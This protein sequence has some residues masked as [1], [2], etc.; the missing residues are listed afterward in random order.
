M[1][2][3][4]IVLMLAVG[5]ASS[6]SAASLRGQTTDTW[7]F[8]YTGTSAAWTVPSTGYYDISASGAQ[9]GGARTNTSS[10]YTLGGL[11]AVVGGGFLL[12]E[13]DVISILVGGVGANGT[14]DSS[15]VYAGGGGG[16]SFVVLTGSVPLVVAGGGGGASKGNNKG[17]YASGL[18][19]STTTTGVS[20]AY[21]GANDQ[22][23]AAPMATVEAS[24][25]SR[26]APAERAVEGSTP[27]G[28][29][30]TGRPGAARWRRLAEAVI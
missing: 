7:T 4:V 29:P 25:A 6:L 1:N 15:G 21:Y 16:G 14:P 26:A 23:R 28:A 11:G 20:A 18:N 12:T 5:A 3:D 30:I 27:A 22:G 10:P 24:A 17:S 19:A 8:T 2:R 9:G 13:G